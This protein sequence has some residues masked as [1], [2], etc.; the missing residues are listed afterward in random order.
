MIKKAFCL[1]FFNV[2]VMSVCIGQ[3]SD[4]IIISQDSILI[5]KVKITTFKDKNISSYWF[6]TAAYANAIHIDRYWCESNSPVYNGFI[7]SQKQEFSHV[8]DLS[9]GYKIKNW[10]LSLVAVGAS[11]NIVYKYENQE[12][13]TSKSHQIDLMAK[14]GY[15]IKFA[16]HAFVPSL[17]YIVSTSSS[18]SVSLP[19]IDSSSNQLQSVEMKNY[20]R[21]GAM[22]VHIGLD[23]ILFRKKKINPFVGIRFSKAITRETS[24][25][26]GLLLHRFSFLP[27]LGLMLKL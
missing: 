21:T 2:I 12:T 5:E 26:S 4:T 10:L 20:F 1:I 7:K 8:F 14:L 22:K 25:S 9:I 16:S 13:V 17:G 23:V 6:I 24:I 27:S 11:N 19:M 18:R 15:R 3:V